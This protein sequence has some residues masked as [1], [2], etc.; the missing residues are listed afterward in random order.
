AAGHAEDE[1]CDLG[2]D[3]EQIV[4]AKRIEIE[5]LEQ[6]DRSLGRE[7]NQRLRSPELARGGQQCENREEIP[8]V[9][10][11]PEQTDR[12]RMGTTPGEPVHRR[13][14]LR[15]PIH[16]AS[17]RTRTASYSKTFAKLNGLPRR[18]SEYCVGKSCTTI[19]RTPV[20]AQGS[21][22]IA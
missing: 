16:G 17:F 3:E 2:P 7:R 1:Q 21:L 10:H 11:A 6:S 8:A 4:R 18:R 20:A 9:D 19:T 14:Q 15:A 5:Q 12:V 22:R 13:L